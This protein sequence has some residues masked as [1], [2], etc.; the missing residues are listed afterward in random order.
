MD[1]RF[2][3]CAGAASALATMASGSE[4]LRGAILQYGNAARQQAGLAPLPVAPELANVAQSYA[5]LMASTGQFSH[6]V[7]GTDVSGRVRSGGF[8]ARYASENIMGMTG[9]GS[10]TSIANTVITRWLN[11]GGHRKNLMTRKARA[12]GVGVAQDSSGV[13]FICQ[14]FAG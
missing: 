9:N 12:T 4:D 14:V 13:F 2:F 3:I 7:G 6:T 8:R 5:A 11:S 10:A 1:R